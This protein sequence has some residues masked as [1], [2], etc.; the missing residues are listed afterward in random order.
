MIKLERQNRIL[1][2]LNDNGTIS[3]SEVAKELKCSEET[4]RKDLV[5]LEKLGKLVRIHG[6]AYLADVYDK[7]FPISLKKT[8]LK[9]EKIHISN[10]AKDY[11]K[12]NMLITLDSST[13]CLEL[14]KKIM[15][16]KINVSVI[17]NS[18]EIAN[19]CSMSNKI[20]LFLAGGILKNN[21]NSFIGHSVLDYLN[22]FV[23]DIA[24]VSYPCINFEFGLGDNTMEDLKI[25]DAMLKRA[26][27]RILLVDHTKLEDVSATVF[28]KNLNID[29]VITDRKINKKWN[30]FFK[31]EG[32]NVKF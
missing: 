10:I 29:T 11:I 13:T 4:I 22:F 6:G 9:E 31:K 15:D 24:F 17:T 2:A 25:R 23:S 30:E 21:S 14:A 7:G 26:K 20:T 18:L 8:L 12:E 16:L 27:L 19:I 3:I 28:S 5:E 1:R 32:I